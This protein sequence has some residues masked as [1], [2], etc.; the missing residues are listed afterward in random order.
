MIRSARLGLFSALSTSALILTGCSG[1]PTDGEPVVI[2][3]AAPAP[4]AVTTP[5]DALPRI[6]TTPAVTP[7]TEQ[8]TTA[9]VPAPEADSARVL[10]PTTELS[11]EDLLFLSYITEFTL[12]E[13]SESDQIRLGLSMCN[14]LYRG[15][16]KAGVTTDYVGDGRYTTAE[17]T[18]VLGAATVSYC[19][20]FA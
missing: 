1:T 12:M 9:R 10:E 20:E 6:Q 16:S 13:K 19:P 3:R 7:A 14:S 8:G 18:N 4:A 5:V 17:I 2:S 15:R 11:T